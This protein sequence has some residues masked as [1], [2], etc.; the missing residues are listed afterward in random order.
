MALRNVHQWNA[1]P[2]AGVPL[3]FGV[4]VLLAFYSFVSFTSVLDDGLARRCLGQRSTLTVVERSSVVWLQLF[5][6]SLES[7]F[8]LRSFFLWIFGFLSHFEATFDFHRAV[9]DN[10]WL[11]LLSLTARFG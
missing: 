9:S 7:F 4:C 3:E 1:V 8:F 11:F 5:L 6:F 10:A 2:C